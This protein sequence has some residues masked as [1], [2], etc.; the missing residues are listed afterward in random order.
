M[1]IQS[2]PLFKVE[3]KKI[4]NTEF[5]EEFC[6]PKQCLLLAVLVF[7]CQQSKNGIL[8]FSVMKKKFNKRNHHRD[9]GQVLY[10]SPVH[11]KGIIYPG[12]RERMLR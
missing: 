9:L 1:Y 12:V 4:K 10:K 6:S 5:H 7:M 2:F 11:Q 8:I 3:G